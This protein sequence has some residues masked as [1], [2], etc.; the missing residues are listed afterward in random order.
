[1]R[2]RKWAESMGM[3]S[4]LSVSN[5]S[6]QPPVFLEVIYLN[7]DTTLYYKIIN[8]DVRLL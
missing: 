2:D 6:E 8:D 3:G 1:M 4:F 5:G 7:Y